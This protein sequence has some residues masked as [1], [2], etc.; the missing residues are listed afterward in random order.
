[1]DR[2]D[3][4]SLVR[5][6]GNDYSVP[7]AYGHREVLV[8]GY[9]YEVVIACAPRRSPGMLVHTSARTSCSAH[10]PTLPCWSGRSERWTRPRRWSVEAT[11]DSQRCAGCS[12]R[13][14]ASWASEFVQVLR[15]LQVFGLD[16]V[17][18]G[19]SEA[20]ARGGLASMPSN[21]WCCAG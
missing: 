14:W 20:M 1:M 18:A 2:T 15:L 6:R 5:Y 13:A 19:I 4:L 7:T 9:V 8:Q 3:S 17:L 11:E 16:D 21:T 12:K 10:C